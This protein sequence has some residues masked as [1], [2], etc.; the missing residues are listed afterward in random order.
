MNI[1]RTETILLEQKDLAYSWPN[2]YFYSA[3]QN[4]SVLTF[5]NAFLW[6]PAN[7]LKHST[8]KVDYTVLYN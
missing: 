6:Q 1:Q 8:R 5:E 3:R 4:R 7:K 2:I